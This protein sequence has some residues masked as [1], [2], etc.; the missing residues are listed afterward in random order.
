MFFF[1]KHKHRNK[2]KKYRNKKSFCCHRVY[3]MLISCTT[4]PIGKLVLLYF[5]HSNCMI[6]NQEVTK[7][8]QGD[9][10]F[11]VT[12]FKSQYKSASQILHICVIVR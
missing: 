5:L 6:G 7:I 12:Y 1:H 2:N 8:R 10:Q 4:D 9:K 11:F 3:C